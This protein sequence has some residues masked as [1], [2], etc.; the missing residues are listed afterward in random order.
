MHNTLFLRILFIFIISTLFTF[1]L[2]AQANSDTYHRMKNTSAKV[3]RGKIIGSEAIRYNY[4]GENLV[5]GH[6][7]EIDVVESFK[8]GD[9]NFKVFVSNDDILLGSDYEYFMFA[10]RN[11]NY[12]NTPKVAFINCI[13]DKSTRMDVSPYPFLATSLRQQIFPIISYTSV[14]NIVDEDTNVVKKGDWM[15]VVD[16]MSNN[17]LPYTISRRRL[18]IG[19]DDILE[20][21]SLKQ[22]LLEFFGR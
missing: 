18:N 20:E 3:I 5:C 11:N 8:G 14:K 4:D 10:R 13:D 21:M 19:N 12:G 15:L 1:E 17:S 9:E 22:F 6:V 2:N 16:R 7:L